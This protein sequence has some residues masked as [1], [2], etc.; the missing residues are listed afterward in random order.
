MCNWFE[1]D[2][3]KNKLILYFTS[4]NSYSIKLVMLH[5]HLA[6]LEYYWLNG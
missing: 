5:E 4:I 2:D 6:F 1:A 3:I